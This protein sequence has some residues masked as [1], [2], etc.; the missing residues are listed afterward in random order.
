MPKGKTIEMTHE[1]FLNT[2]GCGFSA[3]K[4]FVEKKLG[5]DVTII[6][7]NLGWPKTVTYR[8]KK[9]HKKL[10]FKDGKMKHV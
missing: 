1:D 7:Y 2:P 3:V 8:E 4:R 6:D 5:I 10:T 9:P